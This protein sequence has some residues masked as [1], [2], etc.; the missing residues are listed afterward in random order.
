MQNS[1]IVNLNRSIGITQQY[2]ELFNCVQMNSVKESNLVEIA[3]IIT[4]LLSANKRSI[5]NRIMSPGH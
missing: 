2:L 4:T 5:S 1:L 3:I